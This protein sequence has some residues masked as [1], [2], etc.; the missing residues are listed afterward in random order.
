MSTE[1]TAGGTSTWKA[2]TSTTSRRHSRWV[3]FAR[4]VNPASLSTR[5]VGEWLPGSHSG[6]NRTIGSPDRQRFANG[7]NT[8]LGI[9]G[10]DAQ[11]DCAGIANV[12]RCDD[13]RRH[14]SRLR[15]A[16]LGEQASSA[17]G[18]KRNDKDG[19]TPKGDEASHTYS[20]Q[21]ALRKKTAAASVTINGPVGR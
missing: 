19:P 12:L 8:P 4:M 5:P 16:G 18:Q 6:N 15:T 11:P 14:R 3:P 10:V 1:V 2:K 13:R 21:R 7:K 17:D 20:P 9:A